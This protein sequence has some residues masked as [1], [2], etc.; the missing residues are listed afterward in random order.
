MH[1]KILLCISTLAFS[2]LL[3]PAQSPM[4]VVAAATTPV[5][6]K[7]IAPP[8]ET[9]VSLNAALI[10]LA[11]VKAANAETLKKQAATLEKL[12]DLEKAADQIKIFSKRG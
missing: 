4:P 11:E 12:D 2:A 6:P 8:V 10:I 9:A 7:T 1:A 3:A 5:A